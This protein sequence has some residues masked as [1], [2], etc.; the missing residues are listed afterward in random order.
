MAIDFHCST[1][2]IDAVI[3]VLKASTGGLPANW[4][5]R[6]AG[7]EP[8][9][10][11]EHGDLFDYAAEGDIF[12]DCPGII[13]RSLGPSPDTQYTGGI[14]TVNEHIRVIHYR[15]FDQCYTSTGT[16]ET[17]MVKA[18]S[19][20]AKLLAK[21]LFNDPHRKLAVIGNTGTRKEATITS[22]DTN[23]AVVNC[24]WE[25]TDLGGDGGDNST[26]EVSVMRSLAAQVWAISIDV[27]VKYRIG[28][29]ISTGI[30]G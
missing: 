6:A 9:R 25:G 2:I 7:E 16:K 15:K 17:N 27:N 5:T 26:P 1:E 22:A 20:Y 11:L 30:A 29:A 23:G 24:I 4:F 21:A 13:V 28:G 14:Q 18:R 19:R 12:E 3:S 10:L 8:L